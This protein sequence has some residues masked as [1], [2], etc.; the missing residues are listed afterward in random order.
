[1]F[2]FRNK[3]SA[4][5]V[6]GHHA[7]DTK[8]CV[9]CGRHCVIVPGSGTRRGF[10]LDCN[11]FLCGNEYC[12]RNCTPFEARVELTEALNEKNIKV[13]KR[14]VEKYPTIAPI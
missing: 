6:D 4:V 14:I 12:M 9:H 2:G 1:M 7:H 11:G 8:Q 3:A 10:C 13:A 5:V